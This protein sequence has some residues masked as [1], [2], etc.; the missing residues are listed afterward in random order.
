MLMKENVSYL[1]QYVKFTQYCSNYGMI[2]REGR[3]G[4]EIVSKPSHEK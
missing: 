4:S 3:G 1:E 2:M